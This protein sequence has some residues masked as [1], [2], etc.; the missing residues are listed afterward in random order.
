MKKRNGDIVP[1]LLVDQ[2]WAAENHAFENNVAV[3]VTEISLATQ[4][5]AVKSW[6]PR[7][8]LVILTAP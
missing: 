4:I 3:E 5:E 8:H 2:S 1:L 7:E 6:M